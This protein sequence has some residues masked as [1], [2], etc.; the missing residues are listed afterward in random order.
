MPNNEAFST[1]VVTTIKVPRNVQAVDG[2][3]RCKPVKVPFTKMFA[4]TKPTLEQAEE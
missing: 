1:S 3:I 2:G 4:E